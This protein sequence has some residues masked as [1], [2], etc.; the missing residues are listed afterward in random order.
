MLK[1]LGITDKAIS[2]I[3][4]SSN[5]NKVKSSCDQGSLAKAKIPLDLLPLDAAKARQPGVEGGGLSL[6]VVSD[7]AWSAG[8]VFGLKSQLQ[9][10][11]HCHSPLNETLLNVLH[12]LTEYWGQWGKVLE[13]GWAAV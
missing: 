12:L 8:G 2:F 3:M 4:D 10:N 7:R 6:L 13:G 1:G 11:D 9:P 5:G